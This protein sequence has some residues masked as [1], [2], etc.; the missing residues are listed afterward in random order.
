MTI[1][2]LLLISS[3]FWQYKKLK[4]W[5]CSLHFSKNLRTWFTS[6]KNIVLLPV[7]L[8]LLSWHFS[9]KSKVS[10]NWHYHFKI[11]NLFDDNL[12]LNYFNEV[13]DPECILGRISCFLARFLKLKANFVNRFQL[14][15]LKWEKI[16]YIVETQSLT[17]KI[18]PFFL[19][20]IDLKPRPIFPYCW[21]KM[22]ARKIGTIIFNPKKYF[23]CMAFDLLRVFRKC[24]I[25]KLFNLIYFQPTTI[26]FEKFCFENE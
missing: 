18:L 16:Y 12:P 2:C 8:S 4:T 26:D 13:S 15:Y 25:M 14:E 19:P 24:D 1:N 6:R 22:K 5:T 11:L 3:S 10:F 17:P 21:M 23:N 7:V 9:R 20:S